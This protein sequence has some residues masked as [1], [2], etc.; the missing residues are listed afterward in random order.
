MKK[1]KWGIIVKSKKTNPSDIS[2]V[3][4]WCKDSYK[5]IMFLSKKQ[6]EVEIKNWNT[7]YTSW[8]YEV[9]RHPEEQ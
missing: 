2:E 1:S 3:G 4:K 8:I 9:K 7:A 6:A 5:Q